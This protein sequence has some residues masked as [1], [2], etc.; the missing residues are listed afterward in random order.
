M[1]ELHTATTG[2]L[3]ISG[4]YGTPA[5]H[6]AVMNSTTHLSIENL[7]PAKARQ[8]RLAMTE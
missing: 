2:Y 6:P 5:P 3:Y 8:G 1:V 4:N 7:S